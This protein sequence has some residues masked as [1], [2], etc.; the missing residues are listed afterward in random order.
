[1]ENSLFPCLIVT[2][3]SSLLVKISI[4]ALLANFFVISYSKKVGRQYL[5]DSST[6]QLILSIMDI[7]MLVAVKL[8]LFCSFE[9]STSTCPIIA[10][11]GLRSTIPTACARI[12][13]STFLLI[14]NFI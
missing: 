8:I 6:S 14:V 2:V 13:S 5:P 1:M 4:V 11:V 7:S 12:F 10:T 9:A 3:S